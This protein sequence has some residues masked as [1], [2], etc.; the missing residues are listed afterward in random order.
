AAV[1]GPAATVVSGEAA[2]VEGVL[3]RAREE[4]VW[5]RRIPVDYASH[6]PQVE[7]VRERLLTELADITPETGHIAFH[8]TVTGELV[9]TTGL[10]AGY[11]YRNLR[12]PVG[13]APVISA[14]DRQ[15]TGA[16][17]EVSPHPV[18]TASIDDTLGRAG[19]IQTLRRD[20]GG[21]DRFTASVAQAHAAGAAVDWDAVFGGPRRRVPLPTYAFQHRRYWLSSRTADRSVAD[22]SAAGGGAPV[23][24][25]FWEAVEGRDLESLAELLDLDGAEA[26]SSLG[27]VV[28]ALS[29]WWNRRRQ[30]DVL[31]SWR[32]GI[33]WTPVN[34]PAAAELSGDWLVVVPEDGVEEALVARCESAL[35]EAGASVTR[36]HADDATSRE[37]L[38]VPLARAAGG[39]VGG[40]VS[41]LG[42][43]ER[44]DDRAGGVALGLSGTVA[45]LQALADAGIEG[46]LW[47]LTRGAAA[48][49]AGDPPP[50]PVQAQV[51]GLGRVAALEFPRLWGGLADL[52][53]GDGEPGESVLRLLPAVL[54]SRDEDQV[55]LRPSGVAARRMVRAPLGPV[56]AAGPWKPRGTV[57]IAGATGVLGARLAHWAVA[58]GA[59]HL[60][61]ASR[62]GPDAP[63]AA[64]LAEELT[65][66]GAEVTL[67]ACDITD[68]AAVAALIEEAGRRHPPIRTVVHSVTG[69]GLD[70]LDDMTVDRLHDAAKVLGAQV[71][72]ELFDD[73]SLDAF[74]LFSSIAAFWGS[75]EHAAYA[76]ANAHLDALAARR[77]ARGLKATS[78]AW[79]VWGAFNES[80]ETKTRVRSVLY[81]RANRQGLP[82]LDADTALAGLRQA[83][84]RDETFVAV[85]D[86]DWDRFAPLFTSAR[87]SPLLSELPEATAVLG[88]ADEGPAEAGE[89]TRALRTRLSETSRE[90][91]NRFLLDLVRA[92][93]AIVLGHDG[94][95]AVDAERAFK[96]MGFDSLTGVDLRNRLTAETGLSLP[97]TLVFDYPSPRL[98]A[99]FLWRELAGEQEPAPP[100]AAATSSG[101]D[102]I[103]IVG[104]AC[105]FPGGMSSPEDLWRLVAAGGDAIS[106]FPRDRG[107]DL[108]GIYDPDPDLPGK[109]YVRE[110]GFLRA[111]ADFD[112]GFFG[113]SP[114]EA[115]AM[116]PQQRLL[117]ETSWE[118]FERAGIDPA[119]LKGSPTGTFIG[120]GWSEYG[121]GRRS[122]AQEIEGHLLTGSN[123][124]VVS[125][126]IA[127][128]FGLEGPAIS[129]DTACSSSLVALHLAVQALRNGECS[130]ALAGGVTVLIEPGAFVGFSRQQALARDG[131]CKAF[132]AAADGMGLAE[133]VGVVLVERLSDARRNGHE[134]LAVISGS[135]V[136]QDGASNGLAAPNGPSQQR[137]IRQALAN[138]GLSAS[139]VDAVEAHGTGTTL[140]DPIEAQA[141][142]AAYGHDRDP[143]RPLWLGSVK[144]NIGH[145]AS[146]AGAAGVIKSVQ[147][148]RHGVL[149]KTLH[150]DEPSPHIDWSSGTVR[151]LTDTRP[152]PETGRPRRI[153]VSGFGISGTNVHVILEAPPAAE[154]GP[155]APAAGDAPDEDVAPGAVAASGL[156]PLVVSAHSAA[157]LAAQAARLKEFVEVEPAAGPADIGRSLA[158]GRASLRHR[159]VVLAADRAEALNGLTALAAGTPAAGVVRAKEPATPGGAVLVFPGQGSQWPGMGREL[160]RDAPVFAETIA[161]CEQALDPYVDWSLTSILRGDEGAGTLD[162]VDVVQPVLFAVMVGLAR[163]WRSAG[164]EPSA[165]VGHSQGEIA[166]AHVAGGLSLED[167]AKVVALRSR[168]LLDLSGGGAMASVALGRD[169]V[170]RLLGE[171]D[172]GVVVAA[173]NG[174]SST[175]VSGVPD[176]VREVLDR[177]ADRGVWARRVPVDYASHSLQVEAVRDRLI[178]DLAG[179]SPTGGEVSFY[180]T[181]TGELT[182]TASLDPEYWYRNLREPVRFAPVVERL[183]AHDAAAFIEASPHPVLT[184]AIE[185][186][187]R[188]D[189]ARPA[190]RAGAVAT[191]RR[192]RGGMGQFLAGLAEAHVHGT[193]VDW[194]RVFA[195]SGARRCALPTYAFQRRRYWL[196]PAPAGGGGGVSDAGLAAADHPL[197]GA[198][199]AVAGGDERILTGRLSLAAHPWLADHAIGGTVVVPGAVLVEL[200]I[201]AADEVDCEVVADLA[202]EAPLTLARDE[203]VRLQVRIGAPDGEGGRDIG[204]HSCVEAD[205]DADGP[206]WR[207]HAAG[208]L[209]P[210]PADDAEPVGERREW[211]PPGAR[212]VDI[213]RFHDDAADLGHEFGPA[214]RGLRAVWRS[215]EEVL[216]EVALPEGHREDAAR[217]V[218]HPIL[219]DAAQQALLAAEEPQGRQVRI[220][221]SC[222]G[223]RVSA[224]G[225][226]LLRLRMTPAVPDGGGG[227]VRIQ[228]VD[229]DG[230][231][232]ASIDSFRTRPVAPGEI[233][234][235]PGDSGN[236]PFRLRWIPLPG[237][238]DAGGDARE[239]AVVD[240][241]GAGEGRAVASALAGSVNV[242]EYPDLPALASSVDAGAA[243][244][245]VLVWV[246][247][248]SE[249]HGLSAAGAHAAVNGT[250]AML[251]SWLPDARWQDC[252][253][254]VLTRRAVAAG[255]GE[256]VADLGQA[257][258]LG[259]ARSAQGESPDRILLADTDGRT[260]SYS[261]LPRIVAAA[262]GNRESQVALRDGAGLVPRIARG[263]PEDAAAGLPGPAGGTVLIIGGTGTLGAL[264][265]RHLV[266]G[267][268]VR[269]LVLAGRR[270]AG[271]P[272]AEELRAEL[273]E[274]GAS[275]RVAAC[276]AADRDDLAR[277]L[278]ETTA[279]RPLTGVVHAAG[280]LDDGLIGAL[281]AERTSRV[282]RSK[283][284]AALHLHDLTRDTD[285]SMF[286]MFS[287][288]AGVLGG[289]G[290]GNYAAANAF[291]DALA[292]HRRSQG[293][294]A[295]SLA[296][297]LWEQESA[298]TGTLGRAD[299]A[300]MARGGLVPMSTAAALALMDRAREMDEAVPLPMR[301]DTVRLRADAA[302]GILPPLWRDLVRTSARRT[303]R[304]GADDLAAA[305]RGRLS[306]MDEDARRETLLDLVRTHIAVVLGHTAEDEVGP[307]QAFQELGFDSLTGVDLRNRLNAA[308]GLRLPATLVFDHPTP[309]A[310]AERL[311]GELATADAPSGAAADGGDARE[312]EVRRALATIPVAQLREAGILDALL[313]LGGV[314][315]D[316]AASPR[317]EELGDMSVDE[318]VRLALEEGDS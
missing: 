227:A 11:W 180:S 243:A 271:A 1:N 231:P 245:D 206:S 134:V 254:V 68:R 226:A 154:D 86:I 246:C 198:A 93:A 273:E 216:A 212:S 29:S 135:A 118:L 65:A 107:W 54:A 302:A 171:Q 99:D 269:R 194:D 184:G 164:V 139:D 265:A 91:R 175:V 127:Y 28:P 301:V 195:G 138:A 36:V 250:L 210:A 186:T 165:V 66:L 153:G 282:L 79:G 270:G 38:A 300:R 117:L 268:G 109:S 69:A 203:A 236:R 125:G 292:R 317:E 280:V 215:G 235:D 290:Q 166:A 14:L 7:G 102:P 169:E 207:R 40:V 136:N 78:I 249:D 191:L 94:G 25:E 104:M 314:D 222:S 121:S 96:D 179:I 32:Y 266:T 57:F 260:A 42:M 241:D 309:A 255:A 13:F 43:D 256:R 284:D 306:G 172:G 264:T 237:P 304:A 124:S 219:L 51:W 82:L 155:D 225:A 108:D 49:G 157:A 224:S 33:S 182:D 123:P 60:I 12:E 77:R 310:L 278:A 27:A 303:V 205:A 261:E 6:S 213:G 98:L 152:W 58:E 92:Q 122:S 252:L 19:S 190:S 220:P 242:A 72:D 277:L 132:A 316:A 251:Q 73:D 146:A 46:P 84:D 9:D 214:F 318:L 119:S 288:A 59:E 296:W 95:D 145:A 289:P 201:R 18:L 192:D 170:R 202:L 89:E 263:G 21:M 24:A 311:R 131:R 173:W 161:E 189:G 45:L 4:G 111:M 30:R 17:I 97:A 85:S 177:C 159:A 15:G 258:A 130:L 293:L 141:L 39:A 74:V 233:R 259:L 238:S 305:L 26:H 228:A 276:D 168:A 262:V 70:P 208:V 110:G 151:L 196:D 101:G 204:I 114:R 53:A 275:V 163:L 294:P 37:R 105:R 62:R 23:A 234:Q 67:A 52:P 144:S 315:D 80:D 158:V 128:T 112:A 64:R 156:V 76:A 81:D 174:P 181:V 162:R 10:D 31:D 248:P 48:T 148:L 193:E 244:P 239:W 221:A 61:L 199:V 47:C 298:L 143:E 247:E 75:G 287:S 87:P 133:G 90:E 63:G 8:S 35:A 297:G 291:L 22:P 299:R 187:V 149:P 71:L 232:V 257:G 56:A 83:L 274:L 308:T 229:G 167:A 223:V 240:A 129:V 116:D 41:L 88:A 2:A 312:A 5:A 230:R 211:P 115:L 197:L 307:E 295:T 137:V 3:D 272:G 150:V 50:S 100:V 217:F 286:L 34:T 313:R 16:F 285:L 160:L 126:R 218:L 209:S 103:A 20:E 185:D 44:D 283:V 176:A 178:R 253:L 55:A 188:A 106:P 279:E 281:T 147:A 267:H 200:A 120:C 183:A 113:I 140:G 142:I